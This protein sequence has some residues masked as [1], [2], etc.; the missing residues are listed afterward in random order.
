MRE[1]V[2]SV[3]YG[4]ASSRLLEQL[5]KVYLRGFASSLGWAD[6]QLP[7]IVAAKAWPTAKFFGEPRLTS[8]LRIS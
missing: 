6:V 7:L 2:G 8:L 4:Q 5:V 1:G 3:S